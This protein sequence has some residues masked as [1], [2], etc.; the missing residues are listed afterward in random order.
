[1]F[2]IICQLMYDNTFVI[3]VILGVIRLEPLISGKV[4]EEPFPV[5]LH[6]EPIWLNSVTLMVSE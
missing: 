2:D 5:V 4:W 3:T 6:G 1:M